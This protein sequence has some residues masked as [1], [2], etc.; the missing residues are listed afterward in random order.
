MCKHGINS[1]TCFYCNGNFDKAKQ[2]KKQSQQ[3]DEHT[4]QL[5]EVYNSLKEKYKSF[6]ELWVEEEYAIVLNNFTGIRYN[7]NFFKQM[8]YKTAIQ[9]ER[10]AN[11]VKWHYYHLFIKRNDP[12]AGKNL[13]EFVK[14]NN[15]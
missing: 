2:Q 7:T 15:L 3:M 13:L 8:V 11:A 9:L 4:L 10:T 14:K 6:R 12:K 1:E 5:R